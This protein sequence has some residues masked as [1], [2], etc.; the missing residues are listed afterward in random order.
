M[1]DGCKKFL[2]EEEIKKKAKEVFAYI[3][4]IEKENE[5]LRNLMVKG[6]SED[7]DG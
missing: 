7:R 6:E 5:R 4:E 3:I 2:S 1:P